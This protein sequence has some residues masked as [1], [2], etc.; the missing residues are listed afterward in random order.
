MPVR[1]R[2]ARVLLWPGALGVGALAVVGGL[3]LR[4]S[5]LV[6][7]GLA[8][9]LAACAAAGIA[10]ESRRSDRRS[11]IEAAVQAAGC[12]VGGLLALAGIATLAGA[13]VAV[14]VGGAA[15][16]GW[17]VRLVLRDR[18]SGPD[19]AAPAVPLFPTC[20][21]VPGLPARPPAR[22]DRTASPV[23][24]ALPA[25]VWTLTTP[26][27]GQEWLSTTAALAGRL[28]PTARQSLVGR[29]GETLDELERR[30]PDGFARWLAVGPA[31]GSD[32]S[33]YVRGGPVHDGPAADT[34]AA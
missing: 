20:E 1:G 9:M 31:Q 18:S 21:P 22:P 6:A 10:R 30:D 4:A 14:L 23:S 11:T 28:E 7:V 33:D 25:P 13:V 2:L 24:G 15:L 19:A 5:G 34:D 27:L 3:S 29:R 8:G 16:A 17:L 26:A 12:A 32:P